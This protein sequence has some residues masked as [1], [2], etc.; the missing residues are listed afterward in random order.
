MK[1]FHR[2]YC[3]PSDSSPFAGAGE[4]AAHDKSSSA[5]AAISLGNSPGQG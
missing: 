2:R 3:L 5:G 4:M 1:N